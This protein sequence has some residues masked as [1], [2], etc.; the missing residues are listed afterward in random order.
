MEANKMT[1]LD[2]HIHYAMPLNPK[3]LIDVMEY[4][5]TDAANLVIVPHRERVSS[6]PDALMVK[7][8]Y[9]GKFY[10]FSSLDVTKYFMSNKTVGKKFVKHI[11]N[12][13]ACGCD[14]VKMIEGK[15][16]LRRTIPIPDFDKSVWEP[17]WQ[18]AEESEIPILWHVNDPEEFWDPEKIP[19][20]AKSQGWLYGKETINNEVQYLQVLNVLERH[21]K[22]RIIFAHFF[23][24]SA[25]LERL[26]SILNQYPNISIDLTPGI[27][28]YINMSSNQEAAKKFFHQYQDRILYGTDIGARSVLGVG[29]KQISLEESRNR[30]MLVRSFLMGS[31]DVIVKADGNFL[32]GTEDFTLKGLSLPDSILTK[33]FSE[34]FFNMVGRN[35]RLVS[36]R[37]VIAECRHIKLLIKI[38]SLIDKK[39][40]PDYS[41]AN[42]VIKYFKSKG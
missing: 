19:A 6:V 25:Q 29:G 1:F 31:T 24:M 15:P 18:Y 5:N 12:M 30:S 35:P 33:I 3:D 39:V 14:G 36:P 34:N 28:M 20:W 11:K 23:F 2:C 32:I 40:K 21:P 26:A 7:H 4:T 10:V 37:K 13:I 41:C 38:M 17:F 16:E 8:M 22:L 9:P 42:Q 27:E